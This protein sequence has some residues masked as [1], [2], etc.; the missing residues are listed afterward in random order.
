MQRYFYYDSIGVKPY[1]IEMHSP[2]SKMLYDTNGGV[3]IVT[4]DV[5]LVVSNGQLREIGRLG[6]VING[7][8][9][10][11][12][13]NNNFWYWSRIEGHDY[14]NK[15][16]VGNPNNDLFKVL[17]TSGPLFDCGR[18]IGITQS[19]GLKI[20]PAYKDP[21]MYISLETQL[22]N[23]CGFSEQPSELLFRKDGSLLILLNTYPLQIMQCKNNKCNDLTDL[24]FT[25]LSSAPWSEV[26]SGWSET[27]SG[28]LFVPA[29][30]CLYV[31][32][33]N[34]WDSI[35]VPF[36]NGGWVWNYLID[37]KNRIWNMNSASTIL[38]YENKEWFWID[39]SNSNFSFGQYY[40]KFYL[41]KDGAIVACFGNGKIGTTFDGYHW[42]FTEPIFTGD[43]DPIF[44]YTLQNSEKT[45]IGWS[46][47]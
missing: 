25:S 12:D 47:H 13:K 45:I 39:S 14:L 41:R 6:D 35:Q 42:S 8:W 23:T 1:P 37:D 44:V 22:W 4:A 43:S 30:R 20:Y 17:D 36:K 5:L 31:Y 7:A 34:S 21:S 33:G 28:K 24:A 38:K 32:D 15:M 11:V 46:V 3:I 9:S 18:G 40:S 2:V 29:Y 10:I 27:E 26:E 16:S 19:R